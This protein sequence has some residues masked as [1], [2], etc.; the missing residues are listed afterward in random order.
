MKTV[1]RHLA[2]IL[3]FQTLVFPSELYSMNEIK[4]VRYG[5]HGDAS[6][7]V[8]ELEKDVLLNHY[9]TN[10]NRIFELRVSPLDLTEIKNFSRANDPLL[11]KI[12]WEKSGPKDLLL[13]IKTKKET[14]LNSFTL[15]SPPRIVIDI[16]AKER[17]NREKE[18]REQ[19]QQKQEL[20][21]IKIGLS[22]IY[23]RVET[24]D[25][26]D[27][28]NIDIREQNRPKGIVEKIQTDGAEKQ[29]KRAVAF[30]KRRSFREAIK[31][32]SIII[33]R[34]PGSK[35]A[36]PSRFF[37]A[38]CRY[39]LAER[40]P[41][42]KFIEVIEDYKSAIRRFPRSKFVVKA[43]YQIGNSYLKMKFYYEADVV[44]R[45]LVD[46]YQDSPYASMAQL[47][48]AEA[49]YKIYG[50]NE[51]IAAFKTVM[52]EYPG[53]KASCEASYKLADSY[54]EN[55][56]FQ[57]ATVYYEK[58]KKMCPSFLNTNTQT[59]FNMGENYFQS[60]NYHQA[61]EVFFEL[62]NL[63]PKDD[64]G[65]KA[66][67]RI[68]DSFKEQKMVKEALTIYSEVITENEKG[69]GVI[70]SKI[71][72]ADIGA[73]KKE[74][75]VRDFIFSNQYVFDFQPFLDPIETYF[76][77]YAEFP[78]SG[79]ADLAVFKEG[80]MFVENR[81]LKKAIDRFRILLTEYPKSELADNTLLIIKSTIREL[82]K[83]YYN[84]NKYY[85]VIEAY[86]ENNK[87]VYMP[88]HES[89]LP[90]I[91][92]DA[93]VLLFIGDSYKALGLYNKALDTFRKA[94]AVSY[95]N[96]VKDRILLETGNIYRI[97][98]EMAKA[99]ELYQF[100]LRRYPE[101]QHSLEAMVHLG[102]ILYEEKDFKNAS[103]LFLS[104]VKKDG[105]KK[106]KGVSYYLL[107][108]SYRQLKQYDEAIN[109]YKKA[110]HELRK[111][112]GRTN[113]V[114]DYLRDGYFNLGETHLLKKEYQKALKTL[115]EAIQSYPKDK[116]AGWALFT[117][118]DILIKLKKR[119][120]A[121]RVFAIVK[122]K[123][124]NDIWADM[125]H[126]YLQDYNLEKRYNAFLRR[127]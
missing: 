3:F 121:L 45:Q 51:A 36:E 39:Y 93:E 37:T 61:R 125:A 13:K 106:R 57:N 63:I 50:L 107:G 11:E 18:K 122:K 124:P 29:Y 6:R 115:Q 42:I 82:I 23:S 30:F 20:K 96:N 26:V 73:E 14:V 90:K 110:D 113:E 103:V 16:K 70:L 123:Y 69:E 67:T 105:N 12:W 8:F 60:R 112:L 75:G 127:G 72:M 80:K 49:L 66:L 78:E 118:G 109:S 71:R 68:G 54:F 100:L 59:F 79:F 99:K 65:Q 24:S 97:K 7:V 83:S 22:R 1:L 15:K 62:S 95:K 108:N 41:N 52:D 47:R 84:E 126:E 89:Y 85:S 91:L 34:F 46:K 86:H 119:D 10:G 102:N 56:Q 38:D 74:K 53:T 101:S 114:K 111:I 27:K 104:A 35:Y 9:K 88:N 98:G 92:D 19:K 5:R 17:R 40:K 81:E 116:R 58:A 44:F 25:S 4:D 64:I 117:I 120:E 43:L 2:I 32:F 33:Q 87:R 31:E 48:R 77:I 55:K 94:L 28:S 76:R 21:N